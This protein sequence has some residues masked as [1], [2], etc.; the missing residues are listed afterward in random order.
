MRR[1][2]DLGAIKALCHVLVHVSDVRVKQVSVEGLYNL[3]QTFL[4]NPEESTETGGT[5]MRSYFSELD[6]DD[7]LDALNRFSE[8]NDSSHAREVL[9]VLGY[10]EEDDGEN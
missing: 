1:I 4:K 10:E 5:S 9:S 2:I 6:Q 8:N 7:V 3:T